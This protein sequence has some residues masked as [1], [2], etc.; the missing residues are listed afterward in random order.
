VEVPLLKT[1]GPM[2]EYACHEGN[3]DLR[4]LLE[5]YRNLERQAASS[6]QGSR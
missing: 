4:H 3:K 6:Q 1:E 2:F 5:I